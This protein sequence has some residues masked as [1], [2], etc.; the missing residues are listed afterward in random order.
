MVSRMPED[1]YVPAAGRAAFTAF[2]DPVMTL[3]MREGAWR[4]R[5][6]ALTCDARPA[7]VVDIGCG[8]GTLAVALARALPGAR[9]VGVDG[10]PAVLARARGK[11]RELGAAIEYVEA[12]GD[13]LGLGDGTVDVVTCTLVLHHLTSP[14][15]HATLQEAHRVLAPGGTLLVADWG[16]PRDPLTAVG[17]AALRLLDGRAQTAD[18]AAGRVPQV[19]AGAGFGDV[20]LH[21][22]WRT[23]FGRLELL[24]AVR[25][26]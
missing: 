19:I 22:A 3:T 25:A 24:G 14:A 15:K 12:L 20:R 21:N 1:R 17:F 23:P 8:T 6:V 2:Y 4:P 18:H 26:G 11:A 16:R 10:D 5:L 13:D 9:I 7:T